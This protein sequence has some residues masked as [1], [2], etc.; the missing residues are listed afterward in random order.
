MKLKNKI[1]ALFLTVACAFGL[2]VA[3]NAQRVEAAD[4]TITFDDKSKRTVYTTSQQVWEENGITVTNDKASSTSNVGDYAAPARFYKGSKITVTVADTLSIDKIVFDCNSTTYATTLKDSIGSS[5]TI[6]SDKVTVLSVG[7]NE[8]VIENLSV[9]QVRMDSITVTASEVGGAEKTP[10]EVLAGVAEGLTL[11]AK[12]YDDVE[13]PVE[14]GDVTIS[15][16]SDN[17]AIAI[18][19]PD[20][21]VTRGEADVTVKLTATLT[22][23]SASLTKVFDVIVPALPNLP[24]V[25]QNY[26]LML[27]QET[28][29]K[30]LYAIGSIASSKYLATTE[31][32][33][34]ASIVILEEASNGYYITINGQYLNMPTGGTLSLGTTASTVWAYDEIYD[35]L[36]AKSGST[37]Y[38][39]GT[40]STFDT[41]SAS[42]YNYIESGNFISHLVEVEETDAE[43]VAS[44]D[45]MVQFGI[46]FTETVTETE[47]EGTGETVTATLAIV[48][49]NTNLVAG[50]NVETVFG[51]EHAAKLSVVSQYTGNA[52]GVVRTDNQF[53]IFSG[54]TVTIT[55]L[56]GNTISAIGYDVDSGSKGTLVLQA[57]DVEVEGAELPA[58]TTKVTLFASGGQVRLNN[59]SVTYS[60]GLGS[61]I[62]T[63][64]TYGNFNSAKL[65]FV[66]VI[67]ASL[68]ESIN[69]EA[70]AG[71]VLT[72]PDGRKQTVYVPEENI[73]TEADGSLRFAVV[74]NVP[75]EQY[76]TVVTGQAFVYLHDATEATYLAEKAFSVNSIVAHY[77]ENVTLSATEL[78][79]LKAFQEA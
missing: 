30:D 47:V 5:A 1:V 6:S 18:H 3:N 76:D 24:K 38:F 45:T 21:I 39:L 73:V 36:F 35:T 28:L 33:A 50:E 58:G 43:L 70:G 72:L 66:G 11:D 20:A 22:Y 42:S 7:T 26:K 41:I 9:G 15:W 8:Y 34:S 55:S 79:V 46:N 12:F 68:A 62:V 16:T 56:G 57:N 4:S 60:S 2:A 64:T 14:L 51:A 52:G 29:G 37:K 49:A 71:V 32:S 67:P 44:L 19:T 13:L 23:E 78:A 31:D 53:R 61:S 25:G 75:A 74:L 48:E 10:E 54:N 17:D 77:I 69:T 65:R 40:Y 59:F 63:T 27:T